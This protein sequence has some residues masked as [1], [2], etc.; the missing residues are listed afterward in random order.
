MGKEQHLY[1]DIWKSHSV[2]FKKFFE[3]DETEKQ[4]QLEEARFKQASERG[5]ISFAFN[6]EIEKGRVI[7]N[8]AGSA[9]ARD[10]YDYLSTKEPFRKLIRDHKFKINMTRDFKLHMQRL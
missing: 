2:A 3:S 9:V 1:Y 8:I 10:L 6:L 7:N 4:I 5:R